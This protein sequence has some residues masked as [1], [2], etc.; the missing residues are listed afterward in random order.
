MTNH[1]D[2][3]FQ[4]I[5]KS[6]LIKICDEIILVNDASRDNTEGLINSLTESIDLTGKL[7]QITFKKNKGRF[8]ARFEGAL[9][10]STSH[11]LFLD[12]RIEFTSKST[13]NLVELVK[14]FDV[15]QGTIQI[16]IEESIYNLYWDRSHRLI[17]KKNF[18]NQMNG[19]WLSTKN[20][21]DYTSGTGIFYCKRDIFLKAA[22]SFESAPLSDDLALLKKICE[23]QHIWV[24]QELEVI[25]RPRQDL[26]HF[27]K[28][29]WERGPSFVSYHVINS[30]SKM[31][32]PVYVGLFF[33]ALNVIVLI[34]NP[35]FW[36]QMVIIELGLIGF[37]VIIF[38]KKPKEILKLYLLHILVILSFGFGVL[39]GLFIEGRKK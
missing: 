34:T 9:A 32:V 28:R 30:T 2:K 24:T 22:S 21:D 37:S 31:K 8:I 4:S 7:R 27:L 33:F 29:L 17:F 1:L 6:E 38:T 13:S 15:I 12:S 3:L 5:V 14:S 18:Q 36:I 20:F 26:F 10:S 16:P 11:I 19:F 23:I 35:K 39:R 25:W